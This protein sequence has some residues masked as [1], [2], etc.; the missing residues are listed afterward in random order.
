[1]PLTG[2][3]SGRATS[4]GLP[5]RTIE[6]LQE[7]HHQRTICSSARLGRASSLG[8]RRHRRQSRRV[9]R[10]VGLWFLRAVLRRVLLSPVRPDRAT[11]ERVRRL[12]SRVLR[13]AL[14]RGAA[15][16]ICRPSWQAG[17][18]DPDD[19]DDG[20]RVRTDGLDA[21]VRHHRRCRADLAGHRTQPAG[22]L[23]RRGVR[24]LVGVPGRKR[25]TR[26]PRLGWHVAAGLGGGRDAVGVLACLGDVRCAVSAGVVELGLA[27]GVPDRGRPRPGWAVPEGPGARHCGL[28]ASARHRAGTEASAARGF[29]ALSAQGAAGHR[30]GGGRHRAG[31]VLVR[32]SSDSGSVAH[33][34]GAQDR[35]GRRGDRAGGV[36]GL[37]AAVGTPQ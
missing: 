15:R 9:V 23:C 3:Y 35:T 10:L 20:W 29:Q 37:A 36:H 34:R 25:R 27:A 8:C 2:T 30:V 6:V 31:A 26:T 5:L 12:R 16:L 11:A 7:V 32:L 18:H 28:D 22:L 13:P 1:M 21:D 17:R 4:S 24:H 33:R 14:G 19:P